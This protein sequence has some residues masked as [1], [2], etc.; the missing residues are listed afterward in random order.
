MSPVDITHTPTHLISL[1]QEVGSQQASP[2]VKLILECGYGPLWN[3]PCL[4]S[5]PDILLLPTP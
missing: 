5:A 3:F 2:S 1:G 4:F